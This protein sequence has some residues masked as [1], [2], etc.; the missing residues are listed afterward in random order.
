[1]IQIIPVDPGDKKQLRK[2]IDFPHDLY[3]HDPN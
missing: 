2:F 3:A 1:M